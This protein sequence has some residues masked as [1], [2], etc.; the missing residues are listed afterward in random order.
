MVHP[1]LI[2]WIAGLIV[3]VTGAMQLLPVICALALEDGSELAFLESAATVIASGAML[4]I[5]GYPARRQEPRYRESL[6]VVGISWFLVSVYGA[7]PYLLSGTLDAW[8]SVFESFSGFSSTGS[9]NIADLS[10]VAPS[11]LFWRVFTQ[12]LG[13]MGIIVLMVAVLPYLGVGGQI[14]LKNELSGVAGEKLKPR[15]AQ[16]AKILWMV[17]LSFTL[18]LFVLYLLGGE[19]VFDSL[20]LTFST[21]STGGFA[22]WNDSI[23]HYTGWYMPTVTLLFMFMGS[24]SFSLHYQLFT[25][26]PR[27]LFLNPE[28]IF[29]TAVVL[30]AAAVAALSL[31]VS[32]YYRKPGEAAFYALFHSVSVAST[33]GH[34]IRNWADWPALAQGAVFGLVMIGGCTGSTS[35]GLKCVRWLILFKTVHRV[36]RR[37]IH[38]R[39]VITVRLAGKPVPE[40]VLEGV[41]MFFLLYFLAGAAATL[42]LTGMGLDILSAA[43]ASAS[44]L[45]NVGPALGPLGPDTTYAWLPGPAKG[46]LSLL[47]L[48]GRLELYS[49]LVLLLPEFW[50]R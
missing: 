9:T 8:G 7:L 6:A 38:P 15:V 3:L 39:S 45:G 49:L 46:V 28:V 19:G 33:T 14:M 31:F 29:F 36:L 24:I 37:Y 32:G 21:M 5:A 30:A 4:A 18:L 35:G 26:K 42:V 44:S 23:A 25:G 17:Y 41:W 40:D 48:L 22:N 34:S 2:C 47:M 43:S 27:A 13:G 20:C 10:K 16:T 11:I 1:R 12:Y 50:L